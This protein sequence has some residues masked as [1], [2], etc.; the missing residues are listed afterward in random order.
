[1]CATDHVVNIAQDNTHYQ[2]V[3][4]VPVSLGHFMVQ[5]KALKP[6][7]LFPKLALGSVIPALVGLLSVLQGKYKLQYD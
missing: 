1:M 3:H 2:E 4:S 7:Y 5:V 6:L